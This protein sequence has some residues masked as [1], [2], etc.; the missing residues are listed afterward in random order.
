M[1]LDCNSEWETWFD[2]YSFPEEKPDILIYLMQ[3]KASMD[4]LRTTFSQRPQPQE[5]LFLQQFLRPATKLLMR[6]MAR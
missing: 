3:K 5:P 4:A 6:K 1:L 2:Q